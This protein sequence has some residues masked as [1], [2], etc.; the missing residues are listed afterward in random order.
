M[1]SL[2]AK[3]PPAPAKVLIVDDESTMRLLARASLEKNGFTVAEA[4]DGQEA[5]EIFRSFQPDV[6]LMDVLMPKLD[7][8]ATCTALRQLIRGEHVPIIMVTGL[9]DLTSIDRGYDVGA[10]HFITKP[11]NWS[12]L[13]HHLLYVLRASQAMQHRQHLEDQL[14]QSQKMEAV[15]RLAGGVAHDFNNLLTVINGCCDFLHSQ[16]P[17]EHPLQREVVEINQAAEQAASL[18]RQLLAFSRKQMLQPEEFDLNVIVASM[19]RMLRRVIGED[20]DFVTLL[21]EGP[22]PVKADPGQIEQVVMNLVINARDAMPQGGR[23]LIETAKTYLDEAYCSSHVGVKPGP[24]VLLAMSDTGIGMNPEIQARIFDPFF[25]TK[26]LDRGTGLGLATVHGIVNQSGGVIWVYSEPGQ[27]T[28]FKIYLPERDS[29]SL[30]RTVDKPPLANLQGN[31][32][33][34]LVEDEDLVRRVARRILENFSYKVLEAENGP[35]ALQLGQD[36]P[37]PI[38]LLLTD[39]V[40]PGMNGKEL[41]EIWRQQYPETQVLYTSGYTEN[42]IVQ[43]GS[44]EQDTHFIQKPYRPELLARKVREVLDGHP[45][46]AK[47]RYWGEL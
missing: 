29:T 42:A 7:G 4:G 2:S 45:C 32:T 24:Y 18:T 44:L 28:T 39:V 43:Q 20:I 9:D 25:T 11:I 19:D 21:G 27:G 41:V 34:L 1:L 17:E 26:E 8:F 23:L 31:E 14:Y 3:A 35:A 12:L 15:G 30:N 37:G 6:V 47:P 13:S 40:M 36:Y 46:H 38:N 33:I 22:H 5:L 10:T 16:L